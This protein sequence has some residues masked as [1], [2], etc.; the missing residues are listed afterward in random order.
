[1]SLL[2]P[3][4]FDL[5]TQAAALGAQRK[6]TVY[7]IRNARLDPDWASVERKTMTVATRAISSLTQ[8]QGIGDLY[9]IYLTTQR[10]GVDYNLAYI[11]AS[12]NVPHRE[13][14]DTNYMRQLYATGEQ[15]A[16]AG[17]RS[18]KYPPGYS[19]PR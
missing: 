2:Y 19:P 3:P 6:R 12:F 10:D 17:Y 5:T 18:E 8:T 9:R 11:P 14:F 13:E 16:R 7:I 4:S 15:L 1:M